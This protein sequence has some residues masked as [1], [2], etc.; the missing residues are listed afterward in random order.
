[1]NLFAKTERFARRKARVRKKIFGTS[2]SPRLSVYRSNSH[3]YAQII[4]DSLGKTLVAASS[5]DSSMP[6]QTSTKTEVAKAVGDLLAKRAK[7][8]N[9]SKVVFDRGG[10]IFHGRVKTL[11]E[12]CRAG[13]L[14]F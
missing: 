5:R 8:A 2:G 10:R 3:I 13:G 1:M 14:V 9:L 11:A 4:D 12:A 6:Q 7:V